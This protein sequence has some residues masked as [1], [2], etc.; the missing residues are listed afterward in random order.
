[1]QLST[2]LFPFLTVLSRFPLNQY[3]EF[4]IINFLHPASTQL[5]E[6]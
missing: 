5:E 4:K 6:G 3:L 2:N 1:M